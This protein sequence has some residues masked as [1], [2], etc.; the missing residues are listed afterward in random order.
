M[1]RLETTSNLTA[2]A[3][4]RVAPYLNKSGENMDGN[5]ACI[6]QYRIAV[7]SLHEDTELS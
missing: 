2:V 4:L 1:G 3:Y 5:K 6:S 7:E